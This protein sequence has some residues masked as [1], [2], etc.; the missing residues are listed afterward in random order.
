MAELLELTRD[1]R[2]LTLREI[3]L[4]AVRAALRRN[5]DNV[6][7]AA[8]ELGISFKTVY[9]LLNREAKN[10]V[11]PVGPGLPDAS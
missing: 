10:Q 8:G 5:D 11:L 9:N 7:R 2:P 1:G 4:A 3:K 6:I